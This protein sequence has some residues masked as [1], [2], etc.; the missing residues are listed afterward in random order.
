MPVPGLLLVPRSSPLLRRHA[1]LDP[2]AIPACMR[3]ATLKLVGL[4]PECPLELADLLLELLLADALL[5]A[6]QGGLA[7]LQ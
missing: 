3:C 2:V 7:A 4:A 5:L 1:D 6:R